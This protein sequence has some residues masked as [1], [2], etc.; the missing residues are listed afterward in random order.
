MDIRCIGDVVSA[1]GHEKR[2]NRIDPNLR[3]GGN[4]FFLVNLKVAWESV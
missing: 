2:F 4:D 3:D 1:K